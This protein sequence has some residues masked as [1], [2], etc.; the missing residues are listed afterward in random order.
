MAGGVKEKPLISVIFIFYKHL[1]H[2]DSYIKIVSNYLLM[3]IMKL[4]D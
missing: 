1:K 3:V 2:S 4:I